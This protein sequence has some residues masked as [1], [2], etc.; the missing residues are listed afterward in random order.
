MPQCQ[1]RNRPSHPLEN[2]CLVFK[3]NYYNQFT[4]NRNAVTFN[5]PVITEMHIQLIKNL[6]ELVWSAITNFE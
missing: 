3:F 6:I 4:I 2:F 1:P 5:M